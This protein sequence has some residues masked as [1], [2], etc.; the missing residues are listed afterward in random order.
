VGFDLYCQLLAEAV[1]E[2]RGRVQQP[3]LE[4]TVDLPLKAYLP[5]DYV[6]DEK[7]RLSLYQ[8][9]ARATSVEDVGAVALEVRDRFGPPPDAAVN[10]LYAVQ[11]KV[12]SLRAGVA[13]LATTGDDLLVKM[14]PGLLYNREGLS[15]RFG[16]LL[17]VGPSQIR[18]PWRR[19]G[20][21]WMRVLE[22]LLEALGSGFD[23][24]ASLPA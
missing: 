17:A 5:N 7:Q 13:A 2:L 24:A 8:R 21:G 4:V 15:R 9:L 20:P 6:A 3:A 11:V 12:L 18:L 23:L 22:E 1:R 14:Q 16:A 10:L 19:L